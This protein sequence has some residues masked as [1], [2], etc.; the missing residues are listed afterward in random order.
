MSRVYNFS[1]G[2]A[3]LPES[4]L[5][6][7][8]AQML[9]WDGSGVSEMEISHRSPQFEALQ[10]QTQDLLR[11]LMQIPDNYH[12]LFMT[13]G[14]RAQFDALPMNLLNEG[15]TANYLVSGYW[16]HDACQM[17]QKY[18]SVHVVNP[19]AAVNMNTLSTPANW[20]INPKGS[21]FFYTPNET[22]TGLALTDT[23]KVTM[24][25]VADMTSY[26]LS[27][28]YNVSDFGVIFASAQKN[29]GQAG[30]TVV[31]IRDDLIQEPRA[32]TPNVL[33]YQLMAEK[34]SLYN[35]SPTYAIYI[36]NLVL[37]DLKAKGGVTWAEQENRKKAALLYDFIDSS[38]FYSNNI[39][40]NF[41]SIMNVSFMLS[42]G[43]LQN[44]FLQQSAEHGLLNLKGHSA[45][46]GMRASLYNAMPLAGVEALIKFMQN[47]AEQNQ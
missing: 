16:S 32:F 34:N 22:L 37:K 1:A 21:Y 40:K 15:E 11:E 23:P 2:P 25:L 36:M 9:D 30:V 27:Q 17:A 41:R 5:K 33:S 13:G 14:A 26:I 35:T 4:V 43:K 19:S 10:K 47:Y 28:H 31:I 42:N 39:D 29:M 6:T 20:D 44:N 24:P 38:D 3:M 46:G 8:Q 12:I 45:V 18:N 7:A